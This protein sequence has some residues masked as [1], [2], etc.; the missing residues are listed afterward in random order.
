MEGS[1]EPPKYQDWV[2]QLPL[3]PLK[4]R[5]GFHS[6]VWKETELRLFGAPF[7]NHWTF[8]NSRH[9]SELEGFYPKEKYLGRMCQSARS[10][11]P[12]AGIISS[13]LTCHLL[14][15]A[16]WRTSSGSTVN[17]QNSYI[18]R[19]WKQLRKISGT[20]T[21]TPGWERTRTLNC[22]GLTKL[23][24]TSTGCKSTRA[25]P[26]HPEPGSQPASARNSQFQ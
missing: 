19:S 10:E 16:R 7:I 6:V 1:Q 22:I 26:V 3:E 4:K 2:S 17:K 15:K 14:P 20:D 11:D 18:G 25:P 5:K 23:E 12:S 8:I 9:S 21:Q 13:S 24:S